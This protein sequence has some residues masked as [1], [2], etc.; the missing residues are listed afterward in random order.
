MADTIPASIIDTLIEDLLY[1]TSRGFLGEQTY[2]QHP[3]DSNAV[4]VVT[5]DGGHFAGHYTVTFNI[6]KQEN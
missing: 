6:E 5:S 3:D 1:L 4:I 2:V